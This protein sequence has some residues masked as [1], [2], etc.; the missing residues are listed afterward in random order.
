MGDVLSL[1]MNDPAVKLLD[2][3][4]G[5]A[6]LEPPGGL[7]PGLR[8]RLAR[9]I[10]RKGA[11]LTWT[12]ST[13]DAAGAPSFFP[14]LTVWECS[15]S[16]FHLEDFVPVEVGIVDDAPVISDA[17]Q[18]TLLQHGIAFALRFGRLVCDLDPPAP[19]RCILG[20]NVT[21]A[22]FRFHQVRTGEAWNRPDL[23]DYQM[24]RIVVVDV[25]PSMSS[26][27]ARELPEPV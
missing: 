27:R 22:T 25:A 18:R 10:V 9:G 16:S 7:A 20:V 11:V 23:D 2:A 21:N 17:D 15:D 14:D 4:S 1:R 19:A 5:L 6:A 3:A 13:A 26:D 24:E 12:D 8:E